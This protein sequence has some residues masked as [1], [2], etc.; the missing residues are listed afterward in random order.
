MTPTSL[1]IDR[2]D[3][4]CRRDRQS[5]FTLMEVVLA[6]AIASMLATLAVPYFR[7][8]PSKSTLIASAGQIASLLRRDR[9]KALLLHRGSVVVIDPKSGAIQSTL[10]RQ[11][12]RMPI[13]VTLRM[14]P[15]GIGGFT[16]E[17]DGT[18]SGGRIVVFTPQRSMAIDINPL[19]AAVNVSELD[20]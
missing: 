3:P 12:I 8:P 17:A 2:N 20:R 4:P 6:L 11:A 5:G 1:A 9:N 10:L 13:G 7:S 14:T 18:S 16:F 19:S 15:E